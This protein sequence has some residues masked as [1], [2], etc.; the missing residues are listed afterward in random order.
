MRPLTA[1]MILISLS[2]QSIAAFHC[3]FMR[4]VRRHPSASALGVL[5]LLA[6]T[7]STDNTL[8]ESSPFNNDD[9]SSNSTKMQHQVTW[10]TADS[11]NVTFMAHD[12][13]LLRTAALRRGLVSP[14]NG[15]ARLINCRGLG[16]CGT[17]AVQIV[18][19]APS[20][21]SSSNRNS[22]SNNIEPVERN[23]VERMRL[24]LP[25][26]GGNNQP[27]SASLRL[28]CQVQV[29]GDIVVTKRTGFWGQYDKIAHR[30]DAE[31][32]F[33]ELEFLLDSRSPQELQNR[34][35]QEVN[36]SQQSRDGTQK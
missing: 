33:G 12:G 1:L 23:K 17:C 35:S 7:S 3:S 2:A 9:S 34:L 4:P 26:H 30:S 25:P 28:A 6:T 24:S 21:N 11:G 15:R 19:D 18:D 10:R 32:Y 20:D 27:Y 36:S 5:R 22:N 31:T 16:T 29:R 14:H 13:E 8:D